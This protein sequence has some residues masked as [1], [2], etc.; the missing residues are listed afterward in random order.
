MKK[1]LD[2]EIQQQDNFPEKIKT[3]AERKLKAQQEKKSVIFG[4]GMFGMVGWAVTIP[5]LICLA[6]GIY[7][8][9]YIPSSY[10]WTITFLVLGV[11]LGCFNAWYWIQKELN[12]DN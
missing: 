2:P 11:G 7:L 9:K 4:L 6:I 8:D 12:Q 3:K 5:T 1:S 10:S